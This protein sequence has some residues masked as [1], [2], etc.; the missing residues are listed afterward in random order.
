LPLAEQESGDSQYPECLES[1]VNRQL[2]SFQT[3]TSK[4]S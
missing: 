3:K 2:S 4:T 1:S